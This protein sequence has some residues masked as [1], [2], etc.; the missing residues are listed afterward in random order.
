MESYDFIIIGGGIAGSSIAYELSKRGKRCLLLERDRVCKG[1]SYASGAFISPKI[2]KPSFYSEFINRAF[3]YTT[4]LYKKEFSDLFIECGLKKLPLDKSDVERLR[5]YE[6]YIRV[7]FKR[8]REGYFFKSAGFIEPCILIERLLSSIDVVEGYEV[9]DTEFID[10][11]RVGDFRAKNLIIA[12]ADPYPLIKESYIRLK[13][14]GGYR[15]DVEFEGCEDIK[16]NIHKDISISAFT[17]SHIKIGASFIKEKD[18]KVA[19]RE[20]SYG[21][22]KRAK[23]ILN[24][25]DMKILKSLYGYRVMSFDYFPI[26]G[27]VIDMR[28]TL[29]LYPYIKK[30]SKVPPSKFIRHKNLYAILALGSRGFVTA[31]YGAKLLADHILDNRA[32]DDRL[33]TVRLFLRESRRDLSINH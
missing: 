1:S 4:K 25:Q 24:L 10:E 33:S 21:L 31:P 11:W 30:G 19:M 7:E 5:G 15:Y 14:I 2:S 13:E 29:K 9:R 28:E 3:L 6:E 23:D 16:H 12:T 26:I 18:I 27:S 22:I 20:D 8:D 32:V 17:N